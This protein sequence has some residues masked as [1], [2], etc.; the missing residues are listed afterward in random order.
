MVPFLLAL[1]LPLP[2][3]RERLR[4]LL[5]ATAEQQGLLAAALLSHLHDITVA[6][7]GELA[8]DAGAISF[9]ELQRVGLEVNVDKSL[10][11]SC[12]GR[13]PDGN[14]DWWVNTQ[15][16]DGVLACEE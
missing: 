9:E 3:I 10:V 2:E 7:P 14:E 8:A 15:R 1:A 16:H 13:S 11:Y 5:A 4:H 6:V 12:S